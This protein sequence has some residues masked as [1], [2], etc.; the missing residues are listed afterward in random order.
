MAVDPNYVGDAIRKSYA[1]G[2][3]PRAM[4]GDKS[5][6]ARCNDIVTAAA[7]GEYPHF[8]LEVRRA[9]HAYRDADFVF[10]E[11]LDD[12]WG[13]KRGVGGKAKVNEPPLFGGAR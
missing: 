8:V 5:F 6:D 11:E 4:A 2:D 1:G 12:G 9:I 3:G 7:V 13:Q 10:G